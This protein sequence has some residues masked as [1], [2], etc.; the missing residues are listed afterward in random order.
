MN[1]L[2]DFDQAIDLIKDGDTVAFSGFMLATAARE[3]MVK[4]GQRYLSEGRPK[5]LTLS[6]SDKEVCNSP[7]CQQQANDRY[8]LEK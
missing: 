2:M 8:G 1:K 5:N 6:R 4:I 3:M 7:L